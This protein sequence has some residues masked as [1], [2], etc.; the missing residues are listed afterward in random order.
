MSVLE[1]NSAQV[2]VKQLDKGPASK[3]S[4]NGITPSWSPDGRSQIYVRPFPD[5]KSAKRQVS[6]D[7]GMAARWSRNGRELFFIDAQNNVIAVPV[8]LSPTFSAGIARKLFSYT[9]FGSEAN[10]FDP[11]NDG[12]FLASRNVGRGAAESADRLVCGAEL[13][14][15][16]QGEGEAMTGAST[17]LAAALGAERFVVE[18]T[19]ARRP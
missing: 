5:T 9:P 15:G 12:R 3:L 18:I 14:R 19:A 11:G 13:L 16:A 6:V 2:W 4:D 7:G 17:R 10:A 8:R 1:G